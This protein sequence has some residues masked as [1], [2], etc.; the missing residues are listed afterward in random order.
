MKSTEHLSCAFRQTKVVLDPIL[1]HHCLQEAGRILHR[2]LVTVLL[3]LQTNPLQ[4][5][6]VGKGTQNRSLGHSG[7]LECA[8]S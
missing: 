4:L 6:G 3:P 1:Q 7:R 2:G 8:F 5:A